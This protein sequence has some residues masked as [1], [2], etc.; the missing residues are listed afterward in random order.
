LAKGVTFL[1]D[2]SIAHLDIKPGNMVLT[3]EFCL[4]IIDL[5]VAVEVSR[6]SPV[7]TD[8]VGTFPWMAPEI[9]QE[10]NRPARPYDPF[11]A[12]RYSCGQ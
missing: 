2:H 7:C 4:Q 5:D 11:L 12:D 10:D 3:D 8:Y 6:D 1:H 9:E